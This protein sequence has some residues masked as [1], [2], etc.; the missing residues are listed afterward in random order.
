[1]VGGRAQRHYRARINLDE[2]SDQAIVSIFRLNRASIN[3]LSNRIG[4]ALQSQEKR[5]WVLS[6][7]Q[8]LL[9]ALRYYA[10]GDHY[11][12]IGLAFGVGKCAISTSVDKVTAA[13]LTIVGD[14]IRMPTE[15]ELPTIMN[16]F[17][18]KAR[19]ARIIG[20]IDGTHFKIVRPPNELDGP[21]ICRKMFPS[22]NAMAMCDDKMRFR[23]FLA[24]FPGSCHDSYILR[25]L[26]ASPCFFVASRRFALS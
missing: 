2:L 6:P 17:Y 18:Q 26:L 5:R 19:L 12:T 1:V 16:G 7:T 9:I 24:K 20:A 23:M 14:F 10:T 3:M 8:Q 15:E 11:A 25:F 4:P 22:I 21:Y 13:L